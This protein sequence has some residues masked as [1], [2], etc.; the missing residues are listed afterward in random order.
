MQIQNQGQLLDQR[1]ILTHPTD[2][3]DVILEAKA[4]LTFTNEPSEL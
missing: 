4:L 2:D 3:V 1:S